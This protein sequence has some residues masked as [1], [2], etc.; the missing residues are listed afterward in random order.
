MGLSFHDV[1]TADL[2]QLADVSDAWRTMGDRF[3]ELKGHYEKH[4]KGALANGNWLGMSFHAH[5]QHAENS[6]FEFGAAKKEAHALAELL[7]Q[8]HTEMRR[9]QKAVQDLVADAE[10]QDY[11]VDSSGKVSYVGFDELPEQEKRALA[12]DPAH[13]GLLRDAED[14]AHGWAK[15]IDDAVR[16]VDEADQSVRRALL[17]ATTDTSLDGTGY[18]GFNAHPETDLEKAGRPEPVHH[19]WHGWTAHGKAV[20]NGPKLGESTTGVRYGKQGM[21]KKYFDLAHATAQGSVTKDSTTLS[22]IADASV[23]ARGTSSWRLSNEGVNGSMEASAGIRAL[24]EGRAEAGHFATY[25]RA[26]A[27]AGASAEGKVKAGKN[28]AS[29]GVEAFAGAKASAAGGVEAGGIGAGAKG[30][31]WA[32]AGVQAK[33]GVERQGGKFVLT[34]KAGAALGLGA[35]GSFEFTVDPKK[36]EDTAHDAAQTLSHGVDTAKR[37]AAPLKDGVSHLW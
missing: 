23:G 36:V 1:M 16:A 21:H 26:D 29:A 34:A 33:A 31:G 7:D 9:L 22:G 17:R 2:S 14:K 5:Q 24:T 10:E 8:A 12:H 6:A 28:G 13:P 27:F 18:G 37:V 35:E 3:G 32:G 20:A 4:V 19:R 25:G 11:K 30:E 15:K